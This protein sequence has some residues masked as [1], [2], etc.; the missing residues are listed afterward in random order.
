MGRACQKTLVEIGTA[1]NIAA[2]DRT[3]YRTAQ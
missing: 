3:G 1:L 2:A